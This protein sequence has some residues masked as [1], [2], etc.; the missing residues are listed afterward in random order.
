MTI[1]Q[2]KEKF[3]IDPREEENYFT[4]GIVNDDS[5]D[6]SLIGYLSIVTLHR[7]SSN[8][9]LVNYIRDSDVFLKYRHF[10]PL[11]DEEKAK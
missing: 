7:G 9:Y 3:G 5:F 2:I 6:K 11:T 10:R 8:C 4:H 1:E